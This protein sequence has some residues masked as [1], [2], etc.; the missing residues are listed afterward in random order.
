M[1]PAKCKILCINT[2]LR[3]VTLSD[4]S[5]KSESCLRFLGIKIRSDGSISPWYPPSHY[6]NRLW[7]LW[8]RLKHVGLHHYSRAL[9][10]A[11]NIF[12]QPALCFGC[13]IW[14][15]QDVFKCI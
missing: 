8:A 12:V 7:G 13:E 1:D 15:L 14:A 5:L 9:V 4:I 2:P 6:T 11:Y 10:K 3:S